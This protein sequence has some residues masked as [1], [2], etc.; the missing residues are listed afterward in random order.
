M[1][2]GRLSRSE[3]ERGERHEGLVTQSGAAEGC[4][5]HA[6][7]T[8][9]ERMFGVDMRGMKSEGMGFDLAPTVLLNGL[10]H[11]FIAVKF[12]GSHINKGR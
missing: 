4:H 11:L 1:R 3:L 2:T 9:H 12:V 6:D 5:S 7:A 8:A 10:K